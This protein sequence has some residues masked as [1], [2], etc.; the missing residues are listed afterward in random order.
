MDTE[1]ASPHI[2]PCAWLY[3]LSN[4]FFV[5]GLCENVPVTPLVSPG[6]TA[7]HY[8]H[9]LA[10]LRARP[11]SCYFPSDLHPNSVMLDNLFACVPGR[12]QL[13]SLRFLEYEGPPNHP[14]GDGI[15]RPTTALPKWP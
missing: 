14:K 12:V 10:N 2:F 3:S 7:G 11:S 13:P 8:L 5:F 6:D 4:T 15:D 9:V 1:G